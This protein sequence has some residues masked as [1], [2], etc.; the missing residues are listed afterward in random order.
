MGFYLRKSVKV[1]PVRFNLSKSG[2]GMSAGVKGFRFG[3]GPRG[4]YVHMG[5]NGLYYRRFL[6]PTA[7]PLGDRSLPPKSQDP[8]VIPESVDGLIEI[9]S[10]DVS[11]MQDQSSAELLN[12]LNQSRKSM[13]WWPFAALSVL[14][15]PVLGAA[16]HPVAT[17][18]GLAAA[19]ALTVWVYRQDQ[20]RRTTV[21]MFDFDEEMADAYGLVHN[22]ATE[23]SKA[24]GVW[25]IEAEGGVIDRKYQA[26]ADTVVRRRPTF[27]R[28]AEPPRVKTNVETIALGVGRQTLY[29]FP[30]RLLVFDRQGVGAVAYADLNIEV[31]PV[32]FIESG[33]VPRDAQVVDRTWQ[34]VNKKG[35]PDRRF[36]D[37]R[38]L[39]V[40][41]YEYVHFRSSSGLN[42]QIQLSRVGV[43]ENFAKSLAH[44]AE[45][46]SKA[47]EVLP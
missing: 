29:F 13:S 47:E 21:L 24:G 44:I 9:D 40:C 3:T 31:A 5:R 16:L 37:N 25:H 19:I 11:R 6:S 32:N 28:K 33:P 18:L 30:D 36:R 27:I 4:N 20:I 39:P 8:S 22:W 26:G 41:L 12:G 15:A 42:E 2:I 34:Y 45:K 10:A 23:M 35:G 17:L 7:A 43:A 38:E 46:I 14:I 1:G